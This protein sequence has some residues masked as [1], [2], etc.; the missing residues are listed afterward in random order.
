MA[1]SGGILDYF[2][3]EWLDTDINL[4]DSLWVSTGYVLEDLA[5][6]KSLAM[7][8]V[9]ISAD[10]L[11][12]GVDILAVGENKGTNHTNAAPTQEG[13]GFYDHDIP[14]R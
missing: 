3:D 10:I 7:G 13:G 1:K 14:K 4:A 11:A 6:K 12:A 9:S 5:K 8:K 2:Y